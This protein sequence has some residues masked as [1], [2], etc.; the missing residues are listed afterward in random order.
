MSSEAQNIKEVIQIQNSL[1]Q[2]SESTSKLTKKESEKDSDPKSIDPHQ[3]YFLNKD[4]HGKLI[5]SN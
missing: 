3:K 1:K 5:D 2:K 4:N